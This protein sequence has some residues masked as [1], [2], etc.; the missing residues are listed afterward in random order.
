[1]IKVD[2]LKKTAHFREA[3]DLGHKRITPSFILF[4]LEDKNLKIEKDT[5][6]LDQIAFCGV[7]ASKK[8]GGAIKRNRA[9]RRLR[10][11]FRLITPQM[12]LK[13]GR[14][15]FIARA[16][17]LD[18]P[19]LQLKKDMMR[20]MERVVFLKGLPEKPPEKLQP[21]KLQKERESVDKR[22]EDIRKN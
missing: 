5:H 4:Y 22:K 9:K 6:E 17:I 12:D 7:V 18:Y 3:Y 15:V 19:F 20:A 11:A 13:P 2:K 21:E 1:M 14:Y 16:A 8:V 10:E